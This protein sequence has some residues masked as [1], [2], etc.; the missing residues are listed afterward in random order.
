MAWIDPIGHAVAIT[1]DDATDLP[2][3]TTAIYVGGSGNMSV[4]LEGDS[5]AVTLNS[6]AGGIWHP[7]KA[8]RVRSTGTT[9]TGLVAG[10]N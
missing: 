2:W 6:L 10:R 8:K 4:I 5:V 9:A 7:I 3:I 1:P